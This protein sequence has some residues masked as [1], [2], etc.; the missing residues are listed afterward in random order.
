M[1]NE[2]P[3]QQVPL[4]HGGQKRSA[5]TAD[6]NVDEAQNKHACDDFQ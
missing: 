1:H 5:M 4:Q 6:L 2:A 3:A